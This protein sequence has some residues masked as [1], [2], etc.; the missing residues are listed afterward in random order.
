MDREGP[1]DGPVSV[2][3][4]K[5]GTF[6]STIP[7]AGHMDLMNWKMPSIGLELVSLGS[8]VIPV[9]IPREDPRVRSRLITMIK[10]T[11]ID[12]ERNRY[13]SMLLNSTLRC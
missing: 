8:W 3:S 7:N 11:E 10:V 12:Q 4:A 13:F 1:N 2:E 9:M 6:I 5:W